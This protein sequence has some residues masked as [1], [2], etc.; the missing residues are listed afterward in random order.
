MAAEQQHT[1]TNM[2]NEQEPLTGLDSMSDTSPN[3]NTSS[4][5][6]ALTEVDPKS[7]SNINTNASATTESHSGKDLKKVSIVE[8][9]EG[10]SG[11]DIT[12]EALEVASPDGQND[13]DQLDDEIGVSNVQIESGEKKKKSKKR[14]PKSQRGL[15]R[16]GPSLKKASANAILVRRKIQQASRS[17][18]LTL[19]SHQPNLKKSR[20]F[21]ICE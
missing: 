17:T 1:K 5:S 4:N 3:A 14:K 19:P 6:T 2:A 8:A 15:V 7:V 21:M 10:A 20:A 11:N 13:E 12:F 16:C 18:M 9:K